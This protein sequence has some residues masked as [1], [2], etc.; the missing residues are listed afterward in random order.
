MILRHLPLIYG[1]F[2]SIA[3]VSSLMLVLRLLGVGKGEALYLACLTFAFV[4][5]S[6]TRRVMGKYRR[7]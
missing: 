5:Y 3:V 7:N 2:G 4:L 6:I 1:L